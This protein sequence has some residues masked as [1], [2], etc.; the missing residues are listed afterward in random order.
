MLLSRLGLM[1]MLL[2]LALASIQF[3]VGRVLC[4]YGLPYLVVNAWLVG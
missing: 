1:A 4:L 3:S 2:A